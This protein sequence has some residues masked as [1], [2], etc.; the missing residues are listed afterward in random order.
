MNPLPTS[1]EA[2]LICRA[3]EGGLIDDVI[4]GGEWPTPGNGFAAY[5]EVLR[6]FGD[7]VGRQFKKKRPVWPNELIRDAVIARMGFLSRAARFG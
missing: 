4:P 3:I 1:Q 5:D 7:L 2:D 6:R